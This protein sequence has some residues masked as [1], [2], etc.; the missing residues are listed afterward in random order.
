MLIGAICR[1][2]YCSVHGTKKPPPRIPL[3]RRLRFEHVARIVAHFHGVTLED[4]MSMSRVPRFT[5][6]RYHAVSLYI[7][8][9]GVSKNQAAK[10]VGRDRQTVLMGLRR[11]QC[12]AESGRYET[13]INQALK[14]LTR[15]NHEI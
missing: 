13:E 14:A 3:N 9:K 7:E 11:W 12:K 4:I 10:E 2:P 5:A 1:D 8:L 15:Q 6:A